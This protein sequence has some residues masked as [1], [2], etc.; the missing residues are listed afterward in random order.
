[1][2]KIHMFYKPE[3]L[4]FVDESATDRRTTVRGVAWA[5]RGRRALRKV[6]FVRG[7]RCVSRSFRV[8]SPSHDEK[9]GPS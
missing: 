2:N 8:Y 3:Q 5:I 1:M 4:V 6:F 9:L 7:R